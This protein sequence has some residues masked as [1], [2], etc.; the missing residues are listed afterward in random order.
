MCKRFL[1]AIDKKEWVAYAET[2]GWDI[3]LVRR[4]DGFQIGVQAKLRFNIDVINQTIEGHRSYDTDRVGPDCRAVLVPHHG[5]LSTIAAYIGITVITVRSARRK[6]GWGGIRI[7]GI[8]FE[9]NLPSESDR[10]Q[11]EDWHEWAPASRHKLPDYVP[12]VP[13]GASAPLQLTQWK[14]GAIK[15]AIILEKRGWVTRADF[16][17]IGINPQRWLANGNGWLRVVDGKLVADMMPDFKKQH[18]K[19]WKQIA[20]DEDK[21]M[22]KSINEP[23]QSRFDLSQPK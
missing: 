1:G 17:H 5:G 10:W 11:N 7:E 6:P 2:A 9:P 20:A 22:L 8:I 14:I 3:L 21:W 13:A 4:S 16:K 15:I 12:D 23:T 19:V 18:P